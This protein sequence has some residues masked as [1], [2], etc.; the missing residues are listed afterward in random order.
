MGR[1]L[2][3]DAMHGKQLELFSAETASV[4]VARSAISPAAPTASEPSAH[5]APGRFAPF[6]A[7][8]HALAYMLLF[9]LGLLSQTDQPQ[10]AAVFLTLPFQNMG[11]FARGVR[12]RIADL[13]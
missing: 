2:L 4:S 9:P 1:D 8:P 6:H 12:P 3:T 10:G 11:A 13:Y 7:L 5:F